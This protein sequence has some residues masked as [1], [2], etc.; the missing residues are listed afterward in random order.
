M[1]NDLKTILSATICAEIDHWLEK[2]PPEQRRSAVLPA[3]LFAQEQNQGWLSKDIIEAVADYLEI[4][5][6]AAF[7]V[8]TFYSMYELQPIGRYKINVCTNVSCLLSGCEGI[9]EHLKQRLNIGFGE[10]TADGK[11]SLKEV[12]CLGAC[13]NAPMFHIGHQYYEDLTPQKVD[14]ILDGLE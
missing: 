9:V 6:I 14:E 5:H 3:L 7:E 11:F 2:F 4:P 8:A 13:A 12:E 10:T 1:A